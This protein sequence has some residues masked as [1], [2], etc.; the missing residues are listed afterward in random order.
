MSAQVHQELDYRQEVS[1]SNE[2]YAASSPLVVVTP[3]GESNKN[4]FGGFLHKS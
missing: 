1:E 3:T 4:R 2:I